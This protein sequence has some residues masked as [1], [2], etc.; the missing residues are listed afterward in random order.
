MKIALIIAS[1]LLIV[2]MII[3]TIGLASNSFNFKEM[4]TMKYTQNT[5]SVSESFSHVAVD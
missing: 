3:G 4:D 1:A 5:Y 2:G